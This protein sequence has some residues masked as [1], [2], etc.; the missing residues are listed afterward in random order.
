MSDP[1]VR[2][3]MLIRRDAADVFEA[4]ADPGQITRFWLT[5]TTGPLAAGA[6]V[7]WHFKVPGASDEVLVT[8]FERPRLIGFRWSDGIEVSLRFEPRGA[9]SCALRIESRGFRGEH[10]VQD[11]IDA[12]EGFTIVS[13]ELKTLLESGRSAGLVQDKAE[14]IA[15]GMEPPRA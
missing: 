1:V 14:L 7:I 4:F 5:S 12:T 15:A 10:P 8:A 3:S 9:G 13:C 11:A 6:R 2:T